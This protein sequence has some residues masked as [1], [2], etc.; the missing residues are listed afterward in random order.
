MADINVYYKRSEGVSEWL[1][2]FNKLTYAE[3][4]VEGLIDKGYDENKIIY[5]F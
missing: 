5:E 2:S 1:A 4:F 3:I